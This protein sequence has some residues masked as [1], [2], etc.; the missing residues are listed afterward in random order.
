MR[1]MEYAMELVYEKQNSTNKT[2]PQ[3]QNSTWIR[4][5]LRQPLKTGDNDNIK[6]QAGH[7]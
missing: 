7:F 6:I 2:R 5:W 3:L 1:N 4:T